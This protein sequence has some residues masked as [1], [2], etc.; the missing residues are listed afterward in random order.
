MLFECNVDAG[1]IFD[2]SW[3]PVD[4]IDAFGARLT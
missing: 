2:E 1:Y 4:P 3:C